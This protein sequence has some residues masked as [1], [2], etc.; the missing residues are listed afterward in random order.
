MLQNIKRIAISASMV[1]GA[2]AIATGAA[3]AASITNATIGGTAASDYLVYG[4][5]GN[6]TVVIP[7]NPTNVQSVLDGNAGSPTGNVELRAS[8]EQSGFDFTK[9]T[10]LSGNLGGRSITLSSLTAFD[11]FGAG[12]NTAYREN[13]LANKWFNDFITQAGY[14]A[15]VGSGFAAS[16]YNS[17]LSMGGFQASSDPNISYV[18][19]NDNTGVVS[20]GLAGHKD[21]KAAYGSNPNFGGFA[22]LLPNG[23]QASEVVKYT[24]DGKTDYLYSF[25]ATDSGLEALDTVKSHSGNYEVSF[26]G[27]SVP[28]PSTMLGLMTV[29]G[30]FAATKRKSQKTA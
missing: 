9:N 8:S 17:F 2:S 30:L 12:L 3:S 22:T 15:F 4:V 13:N 11:W 18:N 24:Y 5:S 29:G 28:E 21:L 27:A 7:N 10:T 20:I 23:F 26:Q 16:M 6:N 25:F 19:Q 14:G 1:V